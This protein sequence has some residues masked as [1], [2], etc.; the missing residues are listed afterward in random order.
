MPWY[1]KYGKLEDP[2]TDKE[3][4]EGM[5]TGKF[6]NLRQK[7]YPIILYYSAVRKSEALRATRDEFI[8]T[9]NKIIW[10]VG[11]RLKKLRHKQNGKALTDEEYKE[12]LK[13]R[14]R[15]LST[16]PL[17]LPLN[18]PYMDIIKDVLLQTPKGARVWPYCPRTSYNI[19]ARVFKYPHF[20]RLSRITNF[21]LDGWTIPQVRSWTGLS[22]A[23]LNYYVG[24]VDIKKMGE[25]LANKN[26]EIK[27]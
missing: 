18:A 11:P 15:Q 27:S 24:V 12:L 5:E 23:A 7:S 16:P 22:L 25:S 9:K 17:V 2:L 3:F 19:V 26:A 6:L 13:L 14:R 10:D 8:I 20:F 4:R 21:F 1:R